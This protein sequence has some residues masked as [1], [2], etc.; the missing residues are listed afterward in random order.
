MGTVRWSPGALSDL[1]SISEYIASTTPEAADIVSDTLMLASETLSLFPYSG[2]K[3]PEANQDNLRELIVGNYRLMYLVSG[4][5]VEV[6][7]VIHGAR[8]FGSP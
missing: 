5:E 8:L 4:E 3:I 6:L 7:A 2:R 1:N